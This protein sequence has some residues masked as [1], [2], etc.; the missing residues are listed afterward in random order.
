MQ[1][2]VSVIFLTAALFVSCAGSTGGIATSNIPMERDYTVLGN[3]ET[4]MSWW[5]FDVAIIGIPLS[6][7]PIDAAMQKLLNEYDGDALINIRYWTDRTIFL[8]MTRNR[9]HLQADVIRLN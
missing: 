4:T 8:F 1:R 7:P 5:T 9:F 6:E 2:L 3:A